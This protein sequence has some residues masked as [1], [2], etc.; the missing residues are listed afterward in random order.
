[1]IYCFDLEITHLNRMENVLWDFKHITMA[2][3]IPTD[4]TFF[5]PFETRSVLLFLFFLSFLKNIPKT[6]KCNFCSI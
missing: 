5:S 3:L 2:L 4:H 1:M 6:T